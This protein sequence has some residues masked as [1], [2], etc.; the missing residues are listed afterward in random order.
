MTLADLPSYASAFITNSQ[1]FA[2][3]DRIDDVAFT[4]DTELMGA[5]TAAYEAV[6]WD[7]I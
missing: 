1:G 3:V 4:V 6:E 2:P 7:A 5:V